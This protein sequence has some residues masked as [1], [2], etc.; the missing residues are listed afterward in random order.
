[1]LYQQVKGIALAIQ[2]APVT[3]LCARFEN[4][5]VPLRASSAAE[6]ATAS[7]F[8]AN[9]EAADVDDEM[10]TARIAL[11]TGSGLKRDS[12]PQRRAVEGTEA[13]RKIFRDLRRAYMRVCHTTSLCKNNTSELAACMLRSH[14]FVVQPGLRSLLYGSQ[15]AILTDSNL[16]QLACHGLVSLCHNSQVLVRC[17]Y[18]TLPFL[19]S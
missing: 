4:R 18:Q 12:S 9:F 8:G 10:S 17:R 14:E 15:C 19:A 1:M 7:R 16:C 2:H 3:Q 6:G 13:G 5:A 11:A